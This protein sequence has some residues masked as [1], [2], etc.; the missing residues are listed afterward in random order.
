MTDTL[1][2][3]F[4]EDAGLP[5]NLTQEEQAILTVIFDVHG[6]HSLWRD[7]IQLLGL[8]VP[9]EMPHLRWVDNV[10]YIN[11]SAVVAMIGGGWMSVEPAGEAY[12]YKTRNRPLRLLRFLWSQFRLS[13]YLARRLKEDAPWPASQHQQITESLAL[14]IALLALTMRLPR[15]DQTQLA[16]WLA[17]PATSPPEARNT[18]RDIQQIQLRRTRLSPAWHLWFPQRPDEASRLWPEFFWNDPPDIVR[19]LDIPAE[20]TAWKGLPVSG[21]MV[22]GRAVLVDRMDI[23]DSSDPLVLVFPRA[24]PDTTEYFHRAVAIVYA[25]GGA[26]SHACTIAREQGVTC[27]TAVGRGILAALRDNPG[28]LRVDGQSGTVDRIA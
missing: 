20:A 22:T 27:V 14:G 1:W 25:E 18:L 9:Y 6:T 2:L 28:W 11:W 13:L 24:R 12:V 21:G 19:E 23:P 3:R 16:A 4:S 8:A 10:P 15:H 7:A 26:L 5:Q 17:N